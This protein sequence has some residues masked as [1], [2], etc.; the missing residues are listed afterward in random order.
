MI[1]INRIEPIAV[2]GGS[3]GKTVID[4]NC[5]M[6]MNYFNG[7]ITL[8][9]DYTSKTTNELSEIIEERIL[10]EFRPISENN[11]PSIQKD[12][13][14]LKNLVSIIIGGELKEEKAKELASLINSLRK[15]SK[16][17]IENSEKIKTSNEDLIK[18]YEEYKVDFE[19][20]KGDKF[21]FKNR[22]YEVL[23][24]HKS[25]KIWEVDLTT[26]LYKL[27]DFTTNEE[28]SDYSITKNYNKGQ[29]VRYNGVV[30]ESLIDNNPLSPKTSPETWKKID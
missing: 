18:L 21:R 19:Y 7:S 10:N 23:K 16:E 14:F 28:I 26:N 2:P 22:L 1:S 25:Q 13:I 8:I 12:V 5:N 30:Y 15:I 4:Y 17:V 27:V 11:K 29:K 20:K 3:I 9:G 6:G 24:N